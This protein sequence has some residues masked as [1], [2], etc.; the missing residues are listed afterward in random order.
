MKNALLSLAAALVMCLP[1]FAQD[2]QSPPADDGDV[3][4]ITTS[5]IQIDVTV[6]DKK[7]NPIH[8]LRADEVEIY[9]N[10][11]R[12]EI[13][14][15]SFVP[16]ARPEPASKDKKDRAD[17][18][19]PLI[20]GATL[21]SGQVRR[22]IALMVD[23][24]NL[25]FSSHFW[26]KK[27]LKKFVNEQ[28][29]DGDIVAIVRTRSGMGPF[30]QFTTDKRLLMAAI[31]SLKSNAMM[32]GGPLLSPIE[33]GDGE[34]R[35]ADF[36]NAN[37][38]SGTMAALHHVIRGMG[39]MP[40]RKSVILLSDGW[41][42]NRRDRDGRIYGQTNSGFL[43]KLVEF[44]NRNSVVFYTINAGGVQF[45]G[46]TASDDVP[47]TTW[48]GGHATTSRIITK[49]ANLIAD[50]QE[51]L[52]ILADDTGGLR[53]VSNDI[54]HSI[55]KAMNDQSYYL[56]GYLPSDE[57]F[58]PKK[59]P[60]NR[61]E[62]KVTRP[63]V[64][65]RYRSGFFG[66]SDENIGTPPVK[67]ETSILEAL[68]SSFTTSDIMIRM[69]VIFVADEK[70]DTHA[71]AFIN[72]DSRDLTFTSGANGSHKAQFD[73]VAITMSATGQIMDQRSRNLTITLG[74]KEYAEMLRDG[75]L[76]NFEFQVAK[77]GGYQV[78]LVVRDTATG[79]IGSSN[80]YLE[81]PDLKKKRLALSGIVLQGESGSQ[82]DKASSRV[83]RDMA[84]MKFKRGEVVRLAY[85]VMNA[86]ASAQ[87]SADL[88][89]TMRLY[90]EGQLVA[91]F[92]PEP[93]QGVNE[94]PDVISAAGGIKLGTALAAGDYLLHLIVT[95]NQ[96]KGKKAISTQS[97][98]F[99]VVE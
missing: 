72:V 46:I 9:E 41:L 40:G 76:A 38:A 33:S 68:T 98:A 79:K 94:S 63:D 24:L 81:V 47:G 69:N 36:R 35:E 6:T 50:L 42:L 15:F 34:E 4:K 62:V 26:V 87:T 97:V 11:K 32:S 3:V 29:Q 19:P 23:D 89:L 1:T 45:P 37:Y 91:E 51:P 39:R 71:K 59:T 22:T 14:N 55:R 44:A 10:G 77:P 73:I 20:P 82:E 60:F 21:S 53:M 49:R 57:S 5:L 28:M 27:A 75:F 7:G 70:K 86:K 52:S 78:R 18:T 92:A 56:V 58:D 88:T 8:D 80:Q 54:N 31:D 83:V 93:V 99:E 30:Q 2:P 67:G 95:D 66:V 16:G 96:A 48:A 74:E 61:F 84:S 13:S 90:S 65:V 25:S 85:Q 43:P 12:Q 17:L 64:K